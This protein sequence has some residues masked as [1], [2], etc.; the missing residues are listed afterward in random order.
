MEG[1][2][3]LNF[4]P[5]ISTGSIFKTHFKIKTSKPTLRSLRDHFQV[6]ENEIYIYKYKRPTIKYVNTIVLK[7]K[8]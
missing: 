7:C 6:V 8:C 3:L 4:K 5:L 2:A 1:I